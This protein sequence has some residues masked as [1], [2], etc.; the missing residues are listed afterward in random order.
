MICLCS[1]NSRWVRMLFEHSCLVSTTSHTQAIIKSNQYRGN[2][3][4]NWRKWGNF[5]STRIKSQSFRANFLLTFPSWKAFLLVRTWRLNS[6]PLSYPKLLSSNLAG[7]KIRTIPKSVFKNLKNLKTLYL[8]QNQIEKVSG[9][10][11]ADL[12]SLEELALCN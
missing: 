9:A 7:N 6:C 10:A 3:F 8:F 5:P 11:F 1:K 4:K 2:I 12:T